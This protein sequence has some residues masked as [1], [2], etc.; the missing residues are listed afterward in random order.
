M[1]QTVFAETLST[2]HEA[3]ATSRC[4]CAGAN[5]NDNHEGAADLAVA[6]ALGA[7]D[8]LVETPAQTFGEVADKL[9]AILNEYDGEAVESD[10]LAP[11]LSDLRRLVST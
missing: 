1:T 8:A 11:V 10:L 7:L 6:G 4:M 2:Y 5:D 9:A 3:A